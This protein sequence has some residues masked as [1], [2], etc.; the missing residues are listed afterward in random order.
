M[1]V[2][3]TARCLALIAFFSP[4]FACSSEETQTVSQEAYDTMME[5]IVS[6]EE[7][8]VKRYQEEKIYLNT[9]R[10]YPTDQGMYLDLNGRDYAILPTVYGDANGCYIQQVLQNGNR[11]HRCASCGNWTDTA[12]NCTIA[13]CERNPN[14]PNY[15]PPL[16]KKNKKKKK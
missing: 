5:A 9:Q 12:G 14:S 6:N 8:C 3:K 13:E 2:S 11:T 16:Q 7:T 10:I 4:F 1:L 15:K